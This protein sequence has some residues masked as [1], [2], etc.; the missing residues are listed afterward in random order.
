MCVII[1]FPNSKTMTFVTYFGILS[2]KYL[3]IIVQ[4]AKNYFYIIFPQSNS[5]N[6]GKCSFSKPMSFGK[7][8]VTNITLFAKIPIYKSNRNLILRVG[9][10][11]INCLIFILKNTKSTWLVVR[12]NITFIR[13]ILVHDNLTPSCSRLCCLFYAHVLYSFDCFQ[14]IWSNFGILFIS[15]YCA[16]KYGIEFCSEGFLN[17]PKLL[18]W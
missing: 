18:I 8:K 13:S 2:A 1:I 7:F 4:I 12:A 15:L 17:S 5:C 16:Y 10:M 9:G 11:H 6:L 14:Y 3:T